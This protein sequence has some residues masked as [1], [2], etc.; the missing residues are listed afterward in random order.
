[1]SAPGFF[2]YTR[3][4]RDGVRRLKEDEVGV[5][6]LLLT[7]IYEADDGRIKDDDH[8]IADDMGRD[9]RVWRRVRKRLLELRKLT[10]KDGW[11]SNPK[12]DLEIAKRNRISEA[13]S[14]AGRAGG[15][16]SGATRRGRRGLGDRGHLSQTSGE[17]PADLFENGDGKPLENK[18][19]AEAIASKPKPSPQ[20]EEP[21]HSPGRADGARG[22]QEI[23]DA[24]FVDV[25]PNPAAT[26]LPAQAP[27]K[28]DHDLTVAELLKACV[29]AAGPG[30]TSDLVLLRDSAT[31][32]QVAIRA[33]CS[34]DDDIVP[35]IAARTARRRASP[36]TTFA[37]FERAW[38][39][40]RDRRRA[41]P[42][43]ISAAPEIIDE[44]PREGDSAASAP[45]QSRTRMAREA[46]TV[47]R[48][49]GGG[50]MVGAALRAQARRQELDGREGLSSACP[51]RVDEGSERASELVGEAA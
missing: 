9:V 42:P 41:P 17:L 1:M 15:E 16:A 31:R 49:G 13:R 3:D 51:A 18:G 39:E 35:I 43:V 25:D 10:L 32:I 45:R 34:L 2:L 5:Y 44:R 19:D 29:G 33:G 40:A 8:G 23:L 50:G 36:I 20:L 24:E 48:S 28:P 21:L 22:L 27:S 46:K 47:G 11:L 37:Y 4:F 7:L 26:A 12:A 14:E 6:A 38:I 30:L